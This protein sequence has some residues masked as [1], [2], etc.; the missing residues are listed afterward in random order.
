[1]PR[2]YQFP[3]HNSRSHAA[4]TFSARRQYR[5]ASS[6]RPRNS[7]CFHEFPQGPVVHERNHGAFAAAQVQA[8]VPI[9]AR[10]PLQIP[11]APTCSA[12]KSSA[13]RGARKLSPRP[14]PRTAPPR[15]TAPLRPFPLHTRRWQPP[16]RGHRRS[17]HPERPCMMLL[18]SGVGVTVGDL[19]LGCCCRSGSNQSGSNRC[20]AVAL[21]HLA[22]QQFRE[23]AGDTSPGF[24][25][26][27]LITS[28]AV[29]R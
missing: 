19:N 17:R 5:R 28:W 16:A 10:R 3:S 7:C 27:T 11:L 14:R 21:A 12:E 2:M 25:C 13:R 24:V 6:S 20:S 23:C 8:I 22:V 26:T 29:S 18:R 15:R 4:F 1:M 9:R